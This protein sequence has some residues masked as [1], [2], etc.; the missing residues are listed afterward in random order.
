MI[1]KE[2]KKQ[3]GDSLATCP[4]KHRLL[5]HFRKEYRVNERIL[6]YLEWSSLIARSNHELMVLIT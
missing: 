5:N 3:L 6:V 1:S 2:T 4:K